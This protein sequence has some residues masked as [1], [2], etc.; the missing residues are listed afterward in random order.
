[1]KF[2]MIVINQLDKVTHQSEDRSKQIFKKIPALF[3]QG[4]SEGLWHEILNKKCMYSIFYIF[5]GHFKS[6]VQANLCSVD[7]SLQ[8]GK[9]QFLQLIKQNV[10]HLQ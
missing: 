6:S 5:A 10:A 4:M 7:R 2:A 9:F 3:M 1:M 8:T